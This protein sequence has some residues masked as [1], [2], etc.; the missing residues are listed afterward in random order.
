MAEKANME[1]DNIKEVR[2]SLKGKEG[3][4]EDGQVR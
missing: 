2:R 4:D 3:W 1:Q